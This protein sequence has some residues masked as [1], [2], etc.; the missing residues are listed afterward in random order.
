MGGTLLSLSW[1]GQRLRAECCF[2]LGQDE[3]TDPHHLP[4]LRYRAGNCYV[5]CQSWEL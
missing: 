2:C 5:R 1:G 4:L 3:Q